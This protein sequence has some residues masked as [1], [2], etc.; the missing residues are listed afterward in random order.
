ASNMIE[1]VVDDLFAHYGLSDS[2]AVRRSLAK[3]KCISADVNVGIDPEW[4]EV[5]ERLNAAKVGYGVCV[6]KYTGSR[7]KVGSSEAAAEF[8]AELRSAFN[9]SEVKWQMG[10]IGKIDQGGGGTIA[11]FL[12]RYGMDVVDCGTALLSMH[13]PFEIAS[14]IDI[15]HTYKAYTAF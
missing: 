9:R 6:T 11:H 13:S 3:S 14:K 1:R 5:T 12:A 15:F 10:N 7:G 4:K 2:G 8:M